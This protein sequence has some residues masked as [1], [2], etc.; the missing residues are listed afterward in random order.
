MISDF[1]NSKPSRQ[2]AWQ[3]K[4]KANGI[5][6]QCGKEKLDPP[7]LTGPKCRKKARLRMR[8]KMGYKAR[9]RDNRGST[10]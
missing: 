5:C 8:R 3:A 10:K 2:S 9:M 6:P 1:T 4:Q 7:F